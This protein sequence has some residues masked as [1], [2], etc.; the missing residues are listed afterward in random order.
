MTVTVH[1]TVVSTRQGM[2][3][4]LALNP[5]PKFIQLFREQFGFTEEE[6]E[7]AL[8]CFRVLDIPKKG[9]YLRAG[10][11]SN[12]KAYLNKGCAR[13]YVLDEKGHERIVSL[14]FEDWWLGDFGSY[15]SGE[16]GS[17]FI[18][19]LEDSQLLVISK[20]SF[21]KLENDVP[22]LREWYATK[23]RRRADALTKQLQERGTLSAQDRYLNLIKAQPEIF[24]RVDL[25]YIAG[26]L[27]IEPQSLS[28]MRKRLAEKRA[29]S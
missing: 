17:T 4:T 26:Y 9:H 19:M 10:D 14:A 6:F 27:N 29:S 24:Q 1:R 11:I 25:Q 13:C 2:A 20:E 8:R 23:V 18:Q 28:R 5:H 16:P 21:Q 15:Y 7:S 3:D 22:K 12:A